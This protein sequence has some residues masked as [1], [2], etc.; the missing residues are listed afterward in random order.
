MLNQVPRT[1]LNIGGGVD[2][3]DATPR[4]G[5]VPTTPFRRGRS[6][7]NVS[8][9]GSE[10]VPRPTP[11]SRN[12]KRSMSL[13]RREKPLNSSKRGPDE[14]PVVNPA[15]T[16]E[17]IA[18]QALKDFGAENVRCFVMVGYLR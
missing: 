8:R 5:D 9:T 10:L 3:G 15:F 14:P 4:I 2:T 16:N 13:D 1:L 18:D 12:L 11:T 6:G 17:R 7:R